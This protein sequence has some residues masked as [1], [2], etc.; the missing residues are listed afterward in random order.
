MLL[1]C[2]YYRG[3]I[4]EFDPGTRDLISREPLLPDPYEMQYCYVRNS[5]IKGAQE[6]LFAK[7]NLP[8]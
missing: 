5:K 6:G 2:T 1:Y 3:P 7:R 4:Y 8:K